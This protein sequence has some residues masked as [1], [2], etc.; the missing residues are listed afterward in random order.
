MENL[1]HKIGLYSRIIGN[2]GGIVSSLD[3]I[4]NLLDGTLNPENLEDNPELYEMAESI[5]GREV[6]EQMG[7]EAPERPSESIVQ[8]NGDAKHE[9]QMP[10]VPIAPPERIPE[11]PKS[12]RWGLFVFTT[13]AIILIM[14]NLVVGF[15]SFIPL[16]DEPDSETNCEDKL[17]L[18]EI[19]N[20]QSPNSWTVPMELEFIEIGIL[21][22]LTAILLFSLRKK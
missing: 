13:I 2:R 16:C 12:R 22:I 19:A 6:L 1:P 5:Y 9:V 7:V 18:S 4:K 20:Y 3:D 21:V 8:P 10:I 11:N 17:I 15:G 14:T